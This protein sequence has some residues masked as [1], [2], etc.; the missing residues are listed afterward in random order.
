MMGWRSMDD[1]MEFPGG[2]RDAVKK[3]LIIDDTEIANKEPIV[4][5]EG[6]G[7]RIHY[8][9][10]KIAFGDHKYL[11][12][13][14]DRIKGQGIRPKT[15]LDEATNTMT[16]ELKQFTGFLS[17]PSSDLTFYIKPKVRSTLLDYHMNFLELLQIA[18]EVD[19]DISYLTYDPNARVKVPKDGN[20]FLDVMAHI[21]K[22]E[23]E[24]LLKKGLVKDYILRTE[25]MNFLRGKL[26]V[27]MHIQ[28]NY[29][30]PKFYCK[31]Y[32]L[33]YDTFENRLILFA[34][35]KIC[36]QIRDANLKRHL[37]QMM[38]WIRS[39]NI[40]LVNQIALK[41]LERI[42]ETRKYKDYSTLFELSRIIVRESYYRSSGVA[43]NT[44]LNFIINMNT[45]FERAICALLSD[46]MRENGRL[47]DYN[48][49][50]R[51]NALIDIEGMKYI[52]PDFTINDGGGRPEAV[53]D[54]K[55][56]PNP[57]APADYYQIVIYTL[58]LYLKW[59]KTLRNAAFIHYS[60][61]DNSSQRNIGSVN[62]KDY[63][64]SLT[65]LNQP[66]LDNVDVYEIGLVLP[67]ADEKDIR[68][69]LKRDLN[70]MLL[71]TNILYES[72]LLEPE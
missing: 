65:G 12:G 4:I 35:S 34:I 21:F 42:R 71:E 17:L 6:Y 58:V 5:S 68:S 14:L 22:A 56:K 24:S 53:I 11:S 46:I 33:T 9:N 19:S 44:A 23:L 32:D 15:N 39:E 64:Q 60:E 36:P 63:M 16:F 69:I 59:P 48:K 3:R 52:K 29:I 66:D 62:I 20:A 10:D 50:R 43:G 72:T 41:D 61:E 57:S 25:N 37:H 18:H 67:N 47:V 28:R 7:I 45:V 31:Y 8:K 51:L 30:N 70:K 38:H 1:L 54:A 2:K 40:T 26:D 27:G 49:K 13:F 55:Y